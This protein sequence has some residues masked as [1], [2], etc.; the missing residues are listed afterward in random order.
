MHW[1][2]RKKL[3]VILLILQHEVQPKR[4]LR[5]TKNLHEYNSQNSY[6]VIEQSSLRNVSLVTNPNQACHECTHVKF[7]LLSILATKFHNMPQNCEL[8]EPCTVVCW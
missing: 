4:L 7:I 6:S 8:S 3:L 2:K 1:L 5:T